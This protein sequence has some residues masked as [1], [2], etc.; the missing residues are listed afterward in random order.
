MTRPSDTIPSTIATIEIGPL[1]GQKQQPTS[2]R[3][4]QIKDA[5]ARPCETGC[6]GGVTDDEKGAA[7]A[8][9]DGAMDSP[10]ASTGTVSRAGEASTLS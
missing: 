3:I 7:D 8:E 5:I 6:P 2:E 1:I 4:P 9:Y 10:A